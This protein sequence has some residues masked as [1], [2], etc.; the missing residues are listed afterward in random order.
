MKAVFIDA[1][2]TLAAVAERLHLNTD[3]ELRINRQPDITSE[4]IPAALGDA[5]IIIVDH[6]HLPTDIAPAVRGA[7]ACGVPGHGRTLVHEPR[8]TGRTGHRSPCHQGLWRHRRGGM[9]L[10]A[11]VDRLQGLCQDGPW[12]ARRK[13]AAH[14][15]R[16]GDGQDPRAGRLWR[17]RLGNGAACPGRRH[18]GAGMEPQPPSRIRA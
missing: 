9:R 8:R 13:L 15:C 11:D 17:H 14:R 16:A 12:H 18:E 6:T 2:P 5:E 4:Q 10:R 7:Q 1:N 3:P